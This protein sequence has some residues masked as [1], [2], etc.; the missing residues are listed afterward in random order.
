MLWS[1]QLINSMDGNNA[2]VSNREEKEDKERF[3]AVVFILRSD[4]NC[5]NVLTKDLLCNNI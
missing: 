4:F 1:K 2:P 5:F 3:L